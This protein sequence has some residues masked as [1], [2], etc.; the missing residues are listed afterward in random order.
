[1]KKFEELK[2][3][4]LEAEKDGTAFFEKGNKSAGTRFRN[5]LQKSK[6]LTQEIRNEVTAKKNNTK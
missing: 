6:M 3:L 5:A 1:M 2:A 4:I